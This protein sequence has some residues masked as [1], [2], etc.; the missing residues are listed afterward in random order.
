ML[1]VTEKLSENVTEKRSPLPHP[2]CQA[3]ANPY[4]KGKISRRQSPGYNMGLDFQSP[5]CSQA[6][7]P[8][9]KDLFLVIKIKPGWLTNKFY[10]SVLQGEY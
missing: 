4:R 3:H 1:A 9:Y 10:N 5:G 7:F 8:G 6:G 2:G